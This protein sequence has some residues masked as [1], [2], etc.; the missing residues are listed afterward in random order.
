V[1][2]ATRD[3][4]H[5]LKVSDAGIIRCSDRC[6][7]L[8]KAYIEQLKANQSLKTRLKNVRAKL[9][10]NPKDA[11][12]LEALKDIESKLHA[13][14]EADEAAIIKAGSGQPGTVTRNALSDAEFSFATELA[15]RTNQHFVGP[16]REPFPGLDGWLDGVPVQLKETTGGLQA[17][18]TR[19]SQ[20]ELKAVEA[21]R[22]GVE[23]YVKAPNVKVM[24]M[25]DFAFKGPMK[26]IRENKVL[27]KIAIQTGD[28]PIVL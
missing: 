11:D 17:V 16:P 24:E 10:A 7:L 15:K 1:E 19:V 3:G 9:K 25:L 18:L 14:R 4:G 6:E 5:E 12:A 23:V 8:Q 21:A 22:T 27:S 20:A 2:V 13:A 26:T 28:G